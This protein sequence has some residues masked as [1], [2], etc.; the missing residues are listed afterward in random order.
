MNTAESFRLIKQIARAAPQ[1]F[2]L[3]GGGPICR[4]DLKKPISHGSACVTTGGTRS[5]A[6]RRNARAAS[7]PPNCARR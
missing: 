2:V 7:S 1:L 6:V 5:A 3:A 4:P